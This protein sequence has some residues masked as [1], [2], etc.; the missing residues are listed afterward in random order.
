M[1]FVI[2]GLILALFYQSSQQSEVKRENEKLRNQQPKSQELKDFLKDIDLKGY[3]V[4]RIDPD[5]MFFVSPR[6]RS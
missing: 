3:G 6:S 2:C 5:D 4:V 1:A